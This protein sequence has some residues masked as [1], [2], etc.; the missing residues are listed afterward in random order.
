MAQMSVESKVGKQIVAHLLQNTTKSKYLS[1]QNE[2]RFRKRKGVLA[3]AVQ[4][5][6][7]GLHEN[8]L[9]AVKR[10]P[11]NSRV[12]YDG[13]FL[14][15]RGLESRDTA[16]PKPSINKSNK[17]LHRPAAANPARPTKKAAPTTPNYFIVPKGTY[18]WHGTTAARPDLLNPKKL[19]DGTF[20]TLCEAVAVSYASQGF[21]KYETKKD[22]KLRMISKGD[23]NAGLLF[24]EQENQLFQSITDQSDGWL[25]YAEQ[26]ANNACLTN[27]VTVAGFHEDFPGKALDAELGY[28]KAWSRGNNSKAWNNCSCPEIKLSSPASKLTLV[29]GEIPPN[30]T[31]DELKLID[32]QLRKYRDNYVLRKSV[33]T[34]KS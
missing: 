29:V 4:A 13:G 7:L 26:D 6:K 20:F 28:S 31:W 5:Y 15:Y 14:V 19:R 17:K 3:V 30:M 34:K 25:R 23:L 27:G 16:P 11:R 1:D 8:T 33:V 18:L 10:Q 9:R 12:Y 24:P 32:P 21:L 2:L 22:L